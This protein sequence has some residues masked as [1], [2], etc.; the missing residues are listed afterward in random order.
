MANPVYGTGVVH[1]ENIRLKSVQGLQHCWKWQEYRLLTNKQGALKRTQLY[2]SNIIPI[3]MIRVLPAAG[4]NDKNLVPAFCHDFYH[5]WGDGNVS[6]IGRWI[7][8]GKVGDTH[9]GSFLC[10][11]IFLISKLKPGM[12]RAGQ[13][14]CPFVA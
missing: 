12:Y 9:F 14:S 3:D 8:L 11:L 6:M 2:D 7:G 10:S 5:L 1:I 13:V 4:S